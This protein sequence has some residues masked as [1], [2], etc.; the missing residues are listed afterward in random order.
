VDSVWE[1]LSTG[2][3]QT[4]QRPHYHKHV[5]SSDVFWALLPLAST[6]LFLA[7][8]SMS[9]SHK[10]TYTCRIS[11]VF[12]FRS[13]KYSKCYCNSGREMYEG[14]SCNYEAHVSGETAGLIAG[15]CPAPDPVLNQ[16][17]SLRRYPPTTSES[18]SQRPFSDAH[19]PGSAC[20][21]ELRAV[22]PWSS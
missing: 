3:S 7:A 18:N 10:E 19:G 11:Q 2:T 1:R 5:A 12:L 16:L 9:P 13:R 20:Q 8:P 6:V 14:L 15:S 17:A 22:G 21:G 4:S